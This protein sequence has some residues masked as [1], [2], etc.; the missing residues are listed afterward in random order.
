V[1]FASDVKIFVYRFF[2]ELLGLSREL[3][4]HNTI[5]K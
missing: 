2:R 1:N 4:T 5:P 3:Y